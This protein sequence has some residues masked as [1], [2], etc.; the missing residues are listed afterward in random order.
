MRLSRWKRKLYE[1]SGIQKMDFSSFPPVTPPK[2]GEV[3][4]ASL[5]G[6]WA[7]GTDAVKTNLGAALKAKASSSRKQAVPLR[8]RAGPAPGAEAMKKS[9]SWADICN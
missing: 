6:Q 8:H 7:A 3:P 1:F 2:E 5:Q 9:K 4:A